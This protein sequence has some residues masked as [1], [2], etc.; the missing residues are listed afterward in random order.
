MKVYLYRCSWDLLWDLEKRK[1]FEEIGV[2]WCLEK[3]SD[4]GE[5][6]KLLLTTKKIYLT[7]IFEATQI[8]RPLLIYLGENCTEYFPLTKEK[9][10]ITR[11]ILFKKGNKIGDRLSK[12]S[13]ISKNSLNYISEDFEEINFI[14]SI[15]GK[16]YEFEEKS[17]R[18]YEFLEN[19]K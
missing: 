6:E 7:D 2:Q 14:Y 12:M 18:V 1:K 5:V 16:D 11:T 9:S 10:L 15:I 4:S 3:E 19:L 17:L 8:Q 13:T